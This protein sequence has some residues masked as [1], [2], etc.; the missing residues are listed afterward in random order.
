MAWRARSLGER[1]RPGVALPV[2]EAEHP[3][4]WPIS[5]GNRL[6]QLDARAGFLELLLHGLGLVLAD[7]L[8]HRLGRAIHQVLGLLEAETGDLPDR[9]DDVDLRRAGVLEDDRELGLLLFG[10]GRATTGAT[11]TRGRRDGDRRGRH[12]PALLEELAE[13]GDLEDRPGLELAGELLELR[14]VLCL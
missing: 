11:A 3:A 1:Y 7:V 6:F 12:A 2:Q 8:L 5:S 10:R 14:V 9:L 4:D 13:L